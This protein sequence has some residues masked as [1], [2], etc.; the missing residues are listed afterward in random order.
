M[1]HIKAYLLRLYMC[2]SSLLCLKVICSIVII[3]RFQSMHIYI[4]IKIAILNLR[5][6]WKSHDLKILSALQFLPCGSEGFKWDSKFYGTRNSSTYLY[7]GTFFNLCNW[8]MWERFEGCSTQF[9]LFFFFF[10][11]SGGEHCFCIFFLLQS[12]LL[13]CD[14]IHVSR[15][16]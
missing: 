16:F 11:L 2:V 8:V 9:Y 5:P 1:P 14:E 10:I 4:F 13:F 15:Y 3:D 7:I 6:Q 12:L